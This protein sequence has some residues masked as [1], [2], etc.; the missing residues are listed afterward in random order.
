MTVS[1]DLATQTETLQAARDELA[2]RV[3]RESARVF[4]LA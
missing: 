1:C 2:E 4:E 3:E